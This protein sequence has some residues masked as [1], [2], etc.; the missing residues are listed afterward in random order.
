MKKVLVLIIGLSICLQT[1]AQTVKNRRLVW[2][3]GEVELTRGKEV[4]ASYPLMVKISDD[5][6]VPQLATSTIRLFYDAGSLEDLKIENIAHDYLISGFNKSNDVFGEVFGFAGGG[7]V[8][9]QFNLIANQLDPLD[10]SRESVRVLDLSFVVKPGAKIPFCAP[11]V[12]DNNPQSWGRGASEDTG[13]LANDSG[14]VGT[15]FLNESTQKVYLA[16]DEVKNYLW[17]QNPSFDHIVDRP[18][19]KA[20]FTVRLKSGMCVELNRPVA[21]VDYL[22]FDAIR[23]EKK[24]VLLNWITNSEFNNDFF[25][26]QRSGDGVNFEPI[27]KMAGQWNTVELVAYGFLDEQAPVG[28]NY[29]RL[30]Q[31]DR[32]GKTTYSIIREVEI[33]DDFAPD[34]LNISYYPNPSMGEV[35]MEANRIFSDFEL[36]IF[37]SKGALV[38]KKPGIHSNITLDLSVL[39]SG[40]YTLS[41][42]DRSQQIVSTH[43]IVITK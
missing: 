14:I 43:N 34:Q 42:Q 18:G 16:D 33:T 36:L 7:G 37:D 1:Y 32:N 5:S 25:E 38:M 19:D 27:G 30:S 4:R 26:V 29:Y 40:V 9:A 17:E 24:E 39:E 8:F 13:Y 28:K 35:H 41:L 22:T 15:Y 3:I 10:L 12:L 31:V 2:S 20:G 23:G 11:L 6:H 21:P